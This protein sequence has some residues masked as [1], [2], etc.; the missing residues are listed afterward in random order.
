MSSEGRPNGGMNYEE[1][2]A[3]NGVSSSWKEYDALDNIK[4]SYVFVI[5]L[6]VTS[7]YFYRV[8]SYNASIIT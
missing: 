5:S 1:V 4:T 8:A 7:D 6:A 2:K 3:D